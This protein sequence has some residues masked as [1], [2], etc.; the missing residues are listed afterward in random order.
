[1]LELCVFFYRKFTFQAWVDLLKVVCCCLLSYY[2]SSS[3]GYLNLRDLDIRHVLPFSYLP[4]S[5]SWFLG[6][7]TGSSGPVEPCCGTG[8]PT[9]PFTRT[10][11]G[12]MRQRPAE[13]DHIGARSSHTG[14]HTGTV[15]TR[16]R[17]A[18]HCCPRLPYSKGQIC[19]V[20]DAS[21]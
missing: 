19:P 21:P 3:C 12:V 5:L 2:P 9:D 18:R 7:D 15:G 17:P 14:R 16:S 13:A 11:C 4:G 6:A 20:M 8:P 1:M 10:G